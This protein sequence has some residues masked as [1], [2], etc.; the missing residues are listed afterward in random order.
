MITIPESDLVVHPLCLGGNVFGWSADESASHAVLDAY[1]A[2]GGNFI[3]TADVYSEWK[4]G[5]SGGDSEK[6]IGTWM[7]ARGNRDKVVI[8]TKVAKFSKRPGLSATNILAACEESLNRLQSDYIDLYYSHEDDAKVP[9]EETLGAYAQL[10]A[11]GKVRNIAASNF[12]AARL[13]QALRFSAENSLP[14]YIAVQDQYNLM[15]REPFESETAPVLLENS[16]SCLPFFGLA[17]GFLTGKYRPGITI[18]SVRAAGVSDYLNE[19]G[20][21]V[22]EALDLIA[23]NHNA[24]IAAVALGWLRSNPAVSAPIASART[25]EQLNEIIQVVELSA[26]EV[27]T[28]NAI[29]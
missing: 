18:E 15:A 21:G 27:E 22:I 5:N 4:E 23:K 16:I 10:I 17:R 20:Y 9:M 19:K 29:S 7:K 11:Q 12:T 24:S 6:I 25:V 13:A 8:A 3:D 26:T 2:H 1:F 28:L 14:S